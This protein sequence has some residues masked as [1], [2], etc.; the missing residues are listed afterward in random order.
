ME[1]RVSTKADADLS[2]MEQPLCQLFLKH[3]K[4]LQFIP[5][6][7]HLRFGLPFH[8]ENVTRQARF[9]YRIEDGLFFV[10]RCFATHKEY[11]AW[12]QSFR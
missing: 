12:C 1:I 11:G 3:F 4:K 2:R 6:R 10:V 8:V 7:R 9:V 5:P